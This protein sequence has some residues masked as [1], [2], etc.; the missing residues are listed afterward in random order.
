MTSS[1][2][3][4]VIIN[5][6]RGM[7]PTPIWFCLLLVDHDLLPLFGPQVEY[8]QVIEISNALPSK[9]NKKLVLHHRRMVGPFPRHNILG[10]IAQFSPDL[11]AP[12]QYANSVK[13]PLIVA[14]AS[15][16]D[17]RITLLIIMHRTIRSQGRHISTSFVFLPGHSFG[18]ES[19]DIV[20]VDG[21]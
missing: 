9:H 6:N 16:Q 10:A 13:P 15:E 19:P 21:I 20:H 2:H 14:A 3:I 4:E 12:A 1:Y 7:K 17:D 18:V 8:P 5:Q 11:G